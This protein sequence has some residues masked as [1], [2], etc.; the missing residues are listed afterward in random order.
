MSQAHDP[1]DDEPQF[2]ASSSN[3]PELAA[4][5]RAAA[6]TINL[7]QQCVRENETSIC[8]AKLRFREPD[9]SEELGEDQLFYLWLVVED[10]DEDARLFLGTFCEVPADFAKWHAVGDQIWFDPEDV[11]DWM[12]NDDGV[13]RGGYT[14]R[15]HRSRLPE[16]EHEEFDRYSGV[17]SWAPMPS[18]PDEAR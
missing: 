16:H 1:S 7:F 13:V 11:F 2:I 4:A 3:D 18:L 8:T 12:V 6:L 15:V 14:L 9:L 17:R 10:F 5:H